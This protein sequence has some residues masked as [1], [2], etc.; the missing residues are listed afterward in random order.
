MSTAYGSRTSLKI[1]LAWYQGDIRSGDESS[2]SANVDTSELLRA[3]IESDSGR[4]LSLLALSK[5][6][7]GLGTFRKPRSKPTKDWRMQSRL[8]VAK[9]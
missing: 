7:S 1:V 3:P 9:Q 6:S 8:Q 4:K 2:P 5:Q